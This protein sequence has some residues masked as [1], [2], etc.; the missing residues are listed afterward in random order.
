V[1]LS[2]SKESPG[3][4][5]YYAKDERG[6]TFESK[7]SFWPLF[8][9]RPLGGGKSIFVDTGKVPVPGFPMNIGSA[10]GNWSLKPPF[11]NAVRS[12]RAKPFFYQGVITITAKRDGQTSAVIPMRFAGETIAACKKIQAQL[13]A[14]EGIAAL[15]RVNFP[16]T[17]DDAN[18]E[19]L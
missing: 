2:P 10:G 8:E 17:K 14:R 3:S 16:F 11:P 19:L 15:G 7:A 12:F 6:G 13:P 9:F 1:T 5:V 18:Q 4:T